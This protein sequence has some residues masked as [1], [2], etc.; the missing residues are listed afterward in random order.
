MKIS[1]KSIIFQTKYPLPNTKFTNCSA[2]AD[3]NDINCTKCQKEP[4]Q[5][6]SISDGFKQEHLRDCEI[7]E[8]PQQEAD[9]IFVKILCNR[10]FWPKKNISKKA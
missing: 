4:S 2:T 3:K 10:S 8:D 6:L 5:D 7:K 9:M 1:K